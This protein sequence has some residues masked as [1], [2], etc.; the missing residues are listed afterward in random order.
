MIHTT[1]MAPAI[2]NAEGRPVARDVVLAKRVN[3]EKDFV[4]LMRNLQVLYH[5]RRG[6]CWVIRIRI[7]DYSCMAKT[8]SLFALNES[9]KHARII[10]KDEKLFVLIY[11]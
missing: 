4:G 10:G 5:Q 7:T 11:G 6:I 3:Q 1:M 9:K 2:I 8:Y